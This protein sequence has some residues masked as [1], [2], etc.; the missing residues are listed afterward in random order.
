MMGALPWTFFHALFTFP[1]PLPSQSLL[2]TVI[3]S[4]PPKTC[5][6]SLLK[7]TGF[8]AAFFRYTEKVFK[9]PQ[10]AGE[11]TRDRIEALGEAASLQSLQPPG[12]PA[13]SVDQEG[14]ARTKSAGFSCY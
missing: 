1:S 8:T 6:S 4:Q 9:I 3:F 2:L 11:S 7:C 12:G 10:D 14:T 5:S 13:I